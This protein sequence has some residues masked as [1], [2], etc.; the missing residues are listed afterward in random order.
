MECTTLVHI[1]HPL[2]TSYM[3]KGVDLFP[4]MGGG[5]GGVIGPRI[6][7]TVPALG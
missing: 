2:A 6:I 5:R 1:I 4:A 7:G 3:D